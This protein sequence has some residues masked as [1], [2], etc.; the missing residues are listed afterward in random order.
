VPTVFNPHDLQHLHYPQFWTPWE[1]ARRELVY[2]NGCALAASIVVGSQWAKADIIRQYRVDPEKVQVIPEGAPGRLRAL[3]TTEEVR[4]VRE[5]HNLPELYALYPANM[6]PHKNHLGLLDAIAYLRDNSGLLVHLVCTGSKEGG[7]WPKVQ[8]RIS[9]LGLG[10]QVNCLG[11]VPDT[12]IR[13][14]QRAAHCVIQPSLFEASSLPI[15]DAWLD[16]VPVGASDVTALP[17][18]AGDAALLFDPLD[19][20]G[21]ADALGRLWT[22][23][24][25]R[26]SLKRRG[27]RR[28]N[29]FDWN[30]TAKAY[31]AIYRRVARVRLNDEDRF[32]LKWD[33]MADPSGERTNVT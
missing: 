9:A 10:R 18:Q 14:I 11:Y 23:P 27:Q 33:W 28:I 25:L 6:W 17:E 8:E 7:A 26:E 4:Q 16:G 31:R 3:P 2:R 22:Q 32:L 29:D 24:E 15:F 13:V 12:H 20:R 30:R 1:V 5:C 19:T 21:I